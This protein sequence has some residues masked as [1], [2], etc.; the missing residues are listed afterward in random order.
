MTYK[1]RQTINDPIRITGTAKADIRRYDGGLRHLRGAKSYQVVRACRARP[2]LQEGFGYTYNHAA[3]LAHWQGHFLLEYLSNPVSEHTGESHTLLARSRDGIHW[4][5]PEVV[6]PQYWLTAEHYQGPKKELL[7]KEGKFCAVMHQRCGFYQ[8]K[9]GKMLIT[10]FYGI[11]PEPHTAPNNGWGIGRVVREIYPDFT[12]SPVYFIYYNAV[13]GYDRGAA[14]GFPYFEESGDEDFKAACRELLADKVMIQQ[15]WEE[16]RLDKELFTQ[17]GGQALC[18]YTDWAGKIVGVYKHGLCTVTEDGGESWTKPVRCLSLETSTGKVW[19]QRTSDGRYALVYNPS[20]DSMHRWPL[21]V[22]SG[23]D[24][25][26]FGDMLALTDEVAPCRYQGFAKNFGPQYMRGIVEGFSQSPDGDMWIAYSVNKE[27]I[28]ITHAPVPLT[29]VQQGDFSEDFS[30]LEK[31]ETDEIEGWN[32]YSPLWAPVR[33]AKRD[34]KT[35]LSLSDTDPYDRAKAERAIPE[36]QAGSLTFRVM[37]EAV[38]GA[39]MYIELQDRR[40]AAPMRIT[41]SSDGMLRVKG[42]GVYHDIFP[43]ALGT[44]YDLRVEYDCVSARYIFTAQRE[45]ETLFQKEFPFSQ[46]VETVERVLFA[47][48]DSVN[49]QDLEAN[50]KFCTIGDLPDSDTPSPLSRMLI[51]GMSAETKVRAGE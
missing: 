45:G 38:G 42:N 49:R 29:G 23:E 27:D 14:D 6:F 30:K 7:P 31:G 39:P 43:H 37:A 33:Y 15:W 34:G 25:H 4:N 50:G 5:Q 16:Q 12:L 17:H 41:F 3:M 46:S 51:G 47:T 35:V 24:G 22:V 26:L 18:T 11:S 20:S 19:G 40:G 9:G 48:K 13:A 21:A 44:W 28:W 2:D 32:I 36:A 8:T 1:E 10:G